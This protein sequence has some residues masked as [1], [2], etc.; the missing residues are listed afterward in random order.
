MEANEE[1]DRGLPLGVVIVVAGLLVVAVGAF[2]P[3]GAA[4]EAGVE[5]WDN[6]LVADVAMAVMFGAGVL[7]TGLM[8]WF[9]WARGDVSWIATLVF[10][11]AGALV[12]ALMLWAVYEDAVWSDIAGREIETRAGAGAW[13]VL[14]GTVVVVVGAVLMR[15]A[16]PEHRARVRRPGPLET[17]GMPPQAAA[18]QQGQPSRGAAPQAWS[19]AQPQPSA[20]QQAWPQQSSA[21]PQAWPVAQQQQAW[22]PP[23]AQQLPPPGWYPDPQ[24]PYGTAPG[25]RWWDGRQWTDAR[26]PAQ[27][28]AAAPAQPPPPAQRPPAGPESPG[29]LWSGPRDDYR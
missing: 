10:G 4:E 7:V 20:V 21:T 23:P 11:L 26:A 3:Q 14:A 2:L 24:P 18:P 13:A 29:S 12:A 6:T 16:E 19:P 5:L 17:A 15:S 28:S 9:W 22:S 27:P 25:Q 1:T 8:T